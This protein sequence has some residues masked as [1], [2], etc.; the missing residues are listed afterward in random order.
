MTAAT[1]SR[2]G[3]ARAC[4]EARCGRR[5]AHAP[6]PVCPCALLCCTGCAGRAHR[7]GGVRERRGRR[8]RLIWPSRHRQGAPACSV[9]LDPAEVAARCPPRSVCNE[10][11]DHPFALAQGLSSGPALRTR[12]TARKARPGRCPE[13]QHELHV[14][15]EK[16]ASSSPQPGVMHLTGAEPDPLHSRAGKAKQGGG[17]RDTLLVCL[18]LVVFL[19]IVRTRG[20][21]RTHA[22]CSGSS[23]A[24][25]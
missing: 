10:R 14:W 17:I 9:A 6:P 20:L 22:G 13:Q 2:C 16:P 7:D 19:A 8:Q 21:W 5:F 4:R 3:E 11:M 15:E 24:C 25:V 1:S 23:R 18:A 12:S